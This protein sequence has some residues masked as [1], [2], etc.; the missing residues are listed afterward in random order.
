MSRN[1]SENAS[2]VQV[3]GIDVT[4]DELP[5]VDI[6]QSGE[7]GVERDVEE[8]EEEEDDDEEGEEGQG[9]TRLDPHLRHCQ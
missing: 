8:D 6:E 2:A 9:I 7:S 4:R 5:G 3:G 1:S